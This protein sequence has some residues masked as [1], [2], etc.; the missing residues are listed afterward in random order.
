MKN[1]LD[2]SVIRLEEETHTYHVSRAPFLRFTSVTTF[3]HDF[4]PHFDS[5]G[6]ATKLAGKPGTKYAKKT[7]EDILAEWKDIADEGTYTHALIEDW[8]RKRNH[9]KSIGVNEL[10]EI[11]FEDNS[12]NAKALHGVIWLKN[13]MQ[14]HYELYP[15][16]R[17]YSVKYQLAGTADLLIYDPHTKSWI[18]ADWKTNK[19]IST[20]SYSSETGLHD[21]TKFLPNCH[22]STYSLQMSL[23]QYLLET[24]YGIRVQKRI[25]LHLLPKRSAAYQDGVKPYM[26]DY[27]KVNIERMLVRR[28]ELKEE[29][30]LF[31]VT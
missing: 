20:S 23:Y 22:H 9:L 21:S 6:I 10:P 7:V 13:N 2:Q 8:I 19:Q 14:P 25:L 12:R 24:E 28:L 5:V 29:G 31:D 27:H 17:M 16:I 30:N 3:I 4:F 18:I 1:I 11:E 26:L 15:E